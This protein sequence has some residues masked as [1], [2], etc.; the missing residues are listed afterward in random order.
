MRFG[1]PAD[2]DTGWPLTRAVHKGTEA[3]AYFHMHDRE[4]IVLKALL[5][6][7]CFRRG[8]R[9]QWWDRLALIYMEHGMAGVTEETRLG[10]SSGAEDD[11]IMEIT[12]TRLS[13][14]EC[15]REALAICW[16]G[17]EDPWTHLGMLCS[18]VLSILSIDTGGSRTACST[19]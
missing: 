10:S 12:N 19:T 6:Q 14:E 5:N 1:K 8:R 2:V 16:K 18:S 9:G 15:R 13:Q 11:D 7:T 4:V 3:L 17:L